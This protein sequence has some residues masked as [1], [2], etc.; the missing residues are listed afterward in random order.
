MPIVV[1]A[2]GVKPQVSDHWVETTQIAPTIMHLL[3]L[4]P[5]AL[6]AVQIQ[7]TKVL[8]TSEADALPWRHP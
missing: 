4:D 3:G 7:G 1:Y 2:P 8:P 6:Q 5:R